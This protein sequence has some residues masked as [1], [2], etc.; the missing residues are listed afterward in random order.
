MA[1]L[2]I[3]WLNA[4]ESAMYSLGYDTSSKRCNKVAGC[5]SGAR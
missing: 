5:D 3:R 2:K 1:I 4:D